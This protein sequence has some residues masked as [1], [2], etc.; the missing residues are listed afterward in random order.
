M[1]QACD[2]QYGRGVRR[3]HLD[4]PLRPGHPFLDSQGRGQD[5]RELAADPGCGYDQHDYI[6]LSKIEPLIAKPSSPGKVV[7]VREVQGEEIAQA[8]IGASANP[9]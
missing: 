5:W 2:R 9:G 7:A 8:Y 4:I 1:G 6:D 3:H